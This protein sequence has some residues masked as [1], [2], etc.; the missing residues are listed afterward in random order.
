VPVYQPAE[1]HESATG[2]GTH[3]GTF[4]MAIC[5]ARCWLLLTPTGSSLELLLLL[6]SWIKLCACTSLILQ[7]IYASKH[8][9]EKQAA[10]ELQNHRLRCI[11]ALNSVRCL[12]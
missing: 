10:K 3:I 1:A 8:Q 7:L 12:I 4:R 11:V 5:K 6:W 9:V 2:T